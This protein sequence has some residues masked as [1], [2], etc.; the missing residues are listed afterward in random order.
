MTKEHRYTL[1]S[2]K[3]K[4]LDCPYCGAKKHWQRYI[5]IETGEVLP[6]HWGRCD[7][8][9]KCSEWND[10]YKDGYVKMIWK[11]EQGNRSE[12]PTSW[13]PPQKKKAPQVVPIFFDFDTFLTTLEAN[14]YDDN[15]FL[16]NL[17]ENVQ[18]PFDINEVADV[19][20]LY[21]LGTVANDYRSGGITF[22]FIDKKFNIRA[23][24]VK[25]FDKDNH[26]IS[27]NFLHSIIE[28]FY[29]ENNKPLPEWLEAYTK[30]DK[31]VSCLFGEHL[32]SKYP[33]AK[34]YLFE[35]P[36]TAI[37]STLYFGLPETS[38]TICMAVFN[39]S[40]LSFDKLEVLQGRTV[41]VFPD[42]SKDG[43][44]F[45]E[46]EAKAKEYELKMN[47]TR[48]IFSDLLE[49]LAP[50]QDKSKGNDFAD[51]LIKQDW[52]EFRTY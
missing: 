12:Y 1:A 6:E 17:L 25:Q 39:K 20:R 9:G 26:T 27:T 32:L 30:Q 45:R 47:R 19:V 14:R 11:Q 7:N 43:S 41:Y 10:P 46:W 13:K 21:K 33:S 38:N 36:K 15:I 4:K 48:F 22:P 50:E 28:R 35:A 52:R 16:Q 24:Q 29:N 3:V 37:Y 2:N 49:R 44:T 51:Y 34:I 31:K 18:Y 23:I 8:E 5:D 42:L 40:S